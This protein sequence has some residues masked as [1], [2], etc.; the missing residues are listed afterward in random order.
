MSS[1]RAFTEFC[2]TLFWITFRPFVYERRMEAFSEYGQHFLISF[3]QFVLNEKCRAF[4]KFR[5][6]FW[7]ALN[8]SFLKKFKIYFIILFWMF[9]FSVTLTFI[10]NSYFS[11][12]IFW[13]ILFM[14]FNKRLTYVAWMTVEIPLEYSFVIAYT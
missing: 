11:A 13:T 14:A 2:I 12:L 5:K 3:R 7:P 8:N 1:M 4:I 6:A 9:K 10:Y